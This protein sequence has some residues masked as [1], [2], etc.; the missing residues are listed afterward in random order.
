[1]S[2]DKNAK[3]LTQ[4]QIRKRSKFVSIITFRNLKISPRSKYCWTPLWG[5]L[6][7]AIDCRRPRAIRWG[8]QRK[9][10]Q[11]HLL[12]FRG[13]GG[14]FGKCSYVRRCRPA[15]L[16]FSK[17]AF[18]VGFWPR[19]VFSLVVVCRACRDWKVCKISGRSVAI[20]KSYDRNKF[21]YV[22]LKESIWY[23]P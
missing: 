7:D 19:S 6:E 9:V 5:V 4:F 23:S 12:F 8:K 11:L 16:R 2:R 22:S 21:A 10:L 1:M 13:L 15:F 20:S 17:S 18:F 14:G 3:F